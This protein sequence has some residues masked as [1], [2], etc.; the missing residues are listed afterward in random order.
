[1]SAGNF[2]PD[3]IR[4]RLERLSRDPR[5]TWHRRGDFERWDLDD[6]SVLIP[7]AEHDGEFYVVFTH[8]SAELD[9]H[10]GEVSFPGGRPEPEDNTLVET[11]LREAYEEV[12]LHPSDVE[13]FGALTE[14]PTVTGFRIL[15]LAGEYPHPY[16]LVA[17]P[18]EIQ[19]IFEAPLS[20]LA[21]PSIH[22]I[23]QREFGGTVYP[24][25]YFNYEDNLIWGATGHLLYE[26]LEYLDLV[27]EVRNPEA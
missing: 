7:L 25:H 2:D 12:A 23:E 16:E 24:V 13:V 6:A 19:S 20:A 1:M 10:S 8:R 18:D 3:R 4:E 17:S 26:F 15:A 11:A 5:E 14:M 27:D 21:D 9:N 22:R